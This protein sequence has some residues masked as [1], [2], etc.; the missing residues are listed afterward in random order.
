MIL[1]KNESNGFVNYTQP[2]HF[3]V[4]KTARSL[5]IKTFNCEK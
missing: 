2:V 3:K 5:K 1:I 4:K